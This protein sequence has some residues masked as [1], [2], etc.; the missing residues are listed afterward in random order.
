VLK[1][2][3]VPGP[4]AVVARGGRGRGAPVERDGR[5]GAR[6]PAPAASFPAPDA[7]PGSVSDPEPTV[8]LPT[9]PFRPSGVTLHDAVPVDREAGAGVG[10]VAEV[11]VPA[12]AVGR[13][14][15]TALRRSTVSTRQARSNARST[16]SHDPTTVAPVQAAWS[17]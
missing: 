1:P 7:V 14:G 8:T 2:P 16:S 9:T 3:P 13:S 15:G 4:A 11:D 12:L 17:L 5:A 10:V 6:F